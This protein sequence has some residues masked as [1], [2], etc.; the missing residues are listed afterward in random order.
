MLGSYF[1]Y[2]PNEFNITKKKRYTHAKTTRINAA[3]SAR[4]DLRPSVKAIA[5]H[6]VATCKPMNRGKED[7]S[8]LC[9]ANHFGAVQ[10]QVIANTTTIINFTSSLSFKFLH[11]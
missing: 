11:A 10:P 6:I 7:G 8:C 3:T 4:P 5:V 9:G 2:A 1:S